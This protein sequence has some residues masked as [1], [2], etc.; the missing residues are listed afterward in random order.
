MLL[1]RRFRL[2]FFGIAIAL[3]AMT[4][5]AG[6]L[7]ARAVD[8]SDWA[9]AR[10][11]EVQKP[12][13]NSIGISKDTIRRAF[14]GVTLDRRILK[15][16]DAQPEHDRSAGRY[17]SG[18]VS[19]KRV[20]NGRD[21][22]DKHRKLLSEIGQK[23]GVDPIVVLAIWGVET[24]FGASK[25]NSGVIRS[26]ATLAATDA[27]R[28]KFWNRELVAALK[29][30]DARD[31]QV[32]AMTGSWAGAMGHTQFMPTTYQAYAVDFDGDGRRDVWSSRADALASTANYL[33]VSGWK[34]GEPWGF[35]VILPVGFN[36]RYS[37]PQESALIDVWR[38]RGVVP[39][40]GP[41]WAN[42]SGKLQLLLPSGAGG[43]AFLVTRNF[44]AILRYNSSTLYAL[45]IGQLA[46]TIAGAPGLF[47]QWP[48]DDLGLGKQERV[49]LQNLLSE[50]GYEVGTSDGII[51]RQ[52]R[53]AIF[54]YQAAGGLPQDGHANKTLLERLRTKR[55]AGVIGVG[56]VLSRVSEVAQPSPP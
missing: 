50:L 22:L 4:P 56:R 12:L 20:S 41:G 37:S 13:M 26:L 10:W 16:L 7:Q 2:G 48:S 42:T 43:P 6:P 45:A 49:E 11:L 52:T 1:S 21:M 15:L 39:A 35:E 53:S 19:P 44:R 46:D 3:L 33:K 25:G 29:I 36:Y 32:D 14:F 23:F 51:G 47:A 24:S 8:M 27:R 55:Q 40:R 9:F 28:T 18:L 34:A 30:L 17:V 54:A 31:V 38:E 5:I